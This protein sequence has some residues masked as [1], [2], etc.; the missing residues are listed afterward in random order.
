MYTISTICMMHNRWILYA[1]SR[2]WTCPH[3]TVE[4][5]CGSGCCYDGEHPPRIHSPLSQTLP[6]L[7]A[8]V[9]LRPPLSIG[10]LSLSSRPFDAF[11]RIGFCF[12]RHC[13]FASDLRGVPNDHSRAQRSLS[14][15]P[16]ISIENRTN[17]KKTCLEVLAPLGLLSFLLCARARR[18]VPNHEER[19]PLATP[20]RPVLAGFLGA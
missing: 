16:V 3:N 10:S 5:A 8:Q 15:A 1:K 12:A 7:P 2:A 13:T 4:Q 11:T 14:K 20:R 19:C 18:A 17:E 9:A 6:D